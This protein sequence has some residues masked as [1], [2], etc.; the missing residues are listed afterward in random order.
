MAVLSVV[1]IFMNAG[2]A[3]LPTLV[4]PIA[5]VVGLLFTPRELVRVCRER[6]VTAGITVAALAAVSFGIWFLLSDSP[7]QAKAAKAPAAVQID[8][9]KVAQDI[10]EYGAAQDVRKAQEAQAKAA[11]D[12]ARVMM[13]WLLHG[14]PTSGD[15]SPSSTGSNSATPSTGDGGTASSEPA[16]FDSGA[17]IVVGRD[18]SALLVLWRAFAGRAS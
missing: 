7:A 12:K 18:Y 13:A 9:A 15:A 17:A 10:I 2:A 1:P 14:W 6:P 16:A 4:A 5:T 11:D 3:V 8:W